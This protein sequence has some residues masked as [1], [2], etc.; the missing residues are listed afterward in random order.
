[1][2]IALFFARKM[3]GHKQYKN[4]VSARIIN[5]ATLAVCL[6][7][8]AILIAMSTSKG[9]QKE[10]QN[11]TSVFNGHILI[12]LFENNESQ[13]SVLPFEDTD[14]VRQNIRENKN[15]KRFHSI[16][17]KPGMLKNKSHFEGVLFKGVSSDFDWSSL[18]TFIT[19]GRFPDLSNSISKE[20][21][22]S[23]TLARQLDLKV[24]DQTDTYFQNQSNQGLPKKRRFTVSGIYFSGFPDIDQTLL[25]GDLRQIQKI[26]R[27][28]ENMIGGYELFVKDFSLI[29]NTTDQIYNGIPSE[30]NSI[31]IFER[32]PSIFQWISLFDFNVL[33]ILIV[34]I[35]VGVTNM[36]TALLVLILERSRMVGLLK[37]VGAKNRLIQ[38]IF[39]YNGVV[40]MSKGLLFGNLI[41]LGF[42][43][44]Q[45][46]LGWIQL[47]ASTYFVS[48]APVSISG[49]EVLFINLFFIF[50]S[51]LLLWIPSK[52]ILR[53]SPSQVLRFR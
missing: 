5:I 44:S 43:F 19:E 37:A 48:K 26:N 3:Q 28:E 33:I 40:I 39:L 2:N 25:Y 11:K 15:I 6:G 47:D 30:L 53:I 34:M 23:E 46:L 35:L 50:I 29:Q 18:D 32:F 36:A 41:G 21:L 20:I 16:A 52:I 49:L 7:I 10:I 17:L 38:K 4:T 12:T 24:G 13:V 42:Y 31:P 27:W 1:M 14:S 8:S 9:L 22:I 45:S 51:S